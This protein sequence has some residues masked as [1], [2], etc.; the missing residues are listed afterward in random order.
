MQVFIFSQFK[1]TRVS[2]GYQLHSKTPFDLGRPTS[3]S[4]LMLL[5]PFWLLIWL[6]LGDD[7]LSTS[8]SLPS[9]PFLQLNIFLSDS[10]VQGTLTGLKV[11]AV[12]WSERTGSKIVN[13][14]CDRQLEVHAAYVHATTRWKNVWER[15]NGFCGENGISPIVGAIDGKH[16]TIQSTKQFRITLFQLQE[17][18]FNLT[19]GTFWFWV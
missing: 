16:V 13:D 1:Y 4:F 8:S 14:V 5:G 15:W 6:W 3:I 12:K 17:I 19:F 18:L 7:N 2:Y 9:H 11:T 10:W